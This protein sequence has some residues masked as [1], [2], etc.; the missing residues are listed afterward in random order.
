MIFG[1]NN[2]NLL[3]IDTIFGFFAQTF[4]T[5]TVTTDNGRSL[6]G[7][8]QWWEWKLCGTTGKDNND[9][10][11]NDDDIENTQ[12]KGRGLVATRTIR[13]RETI[14]VER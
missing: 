9:D 1:Q 3:S 13:P 4:E 5:V 6:Q 14:L 7:R 2:D 10:N 11:D 12:G 8:K